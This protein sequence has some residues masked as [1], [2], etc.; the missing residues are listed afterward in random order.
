M[1]GIAGV[2]SVHADA[3]VDASLAQMVCVQRHRGPDGQGVWVGTV[4]RTRLGLGSV[5]LAIQD[6]SDAGRQPMASPSG[7]HVLVYNG[8]VYNYL[9][10]RH[11]LERLGVAFRSRCDTE[12]VLH[13]LAVWGERAF[14]RFNGMWGLAWLDVE[15]GTLLL[16]R[17]RLGIKPLYWHRS[18]GRLLFASEI[19]AVLV[20]SDHRFALDRAVVARYLL[21]S[22]LDGQEQTFFAGIEAVP[23]GCVARF[24][25]RGTTSLTPTLHRYWSPPPE[26]LE[27][28][29]APSVDALRET[30]LD[31]VRLQLRSDVPIGVL[32]SGGLDSSSVAVATQR[33]TGRN[34]ALHLLSIVSEEPR[35]SEEPFINRVAAHLGSGAHSTR[36]QI[37]AEEAF[38]LLDRVTWFN[39]EPLGS[40]SNVA[41]YLL[42]RRAAEL[43]VT[44]I[45]CGQGADELLC[46]YLKYWGFYLQSLCRRGEWVAALKVLGGL[47]RQGTAL[48]QFHVS[49]AKR[50]LPRT[51]RPAEIDI[52]GPRLK[53]VE[54]WLDV[55]L[56]RGSVVERQYAD[57]SRF[58]VPAILHWEDRMSMALGREMRVPY[59]DH[60]LVTLLLPLAPEWKLRDGWSKWVF[61][62][63]MEPYLP[64]E[65]AWRKDK[66][67]F[68]IP[69]SEWFK[70]T[71]RPRVEGLLGGDLLTAAAGFVDRAALARRY[72]AF[73]RQPPD[74]GTISFKDIFHPIA[75]EYWM[76]R[77]ESYLDLSA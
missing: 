47:T 72:T 5:R 9:E 49:D 57:L 66:Q 50:Y 34:A 74:R 4:G 29:G 31:S 46:G 70:T 53:G 65:I 16:A 19:K 59:F 60:R 14:E 13:A 2:L 58:S 3:P 38:D 23:P 71:L 6:L 64:R 76:R 48:R 39:D 51:L 22:Q 10:L 67:G 25:L 56:G 54:S 30:F 17:D 1:C 18:N 15:T 61:R 77:F 12:V 40:L 24:E 43:G 21:Q 33:A 68:V 73:R 27:P 35:Y 20:A 11:E 41:H 28:D 55:G 75:L 52:R 62:R 8:E 36:V 63:A 42:M 69:Q 44:V 7:R 32:L 37:R 26:P 45:L